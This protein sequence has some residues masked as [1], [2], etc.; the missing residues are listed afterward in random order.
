MKKHWYSG[1][2]LKMASVL[3]ALLFI[4]LIFSGCGG[5]GGGDGTAAITNPASS[6]TT[7]VGYDF[8]K[9]TVKDMVLTAD[10]ED[11][12]YDRLEKLLN[13][14]YCYAANAPKRA[15]AVPYLASIVLSKKT[16]EVQTSASYDLAGITV[17]STMSSGTTEV[18]TPVWAIYSGV[19]AL[20]GS[21]YTAP[22]VAGTTVFIACYKKDDVTRYAIFRLKMNGLSSLVLSKTTDE[23]V[24]AGTYDL[25]GITVSA[26]SSTGALVDVT[27]NPNTKWA[28]ASG[29][30]T[31]VGTTYVAPA[32][33][34]TSVFTVSYVE[35]G[36]VQ[37]TMF[38]LK[39]NGL[40]SLVLSKYTDEVLLST[41]PA[42]YDLSAIA[43][44][45]KYSNGTIKD[46]TA[47]PNLTWTLY[48][49]KGTLNGKIYTTAAYAETAVLTANYTE[50]GMTK[51]ANFVLKVNALYSIFLNKTT[52]EIWL[53]T[54]PA[55]YDLSSIVVSAKY[56]NSAIKDV[57]S[58]PNTVWT[59]Y[60]GKGTLSGKVYTTAAYAETATLK[61]T[62]TEAGVSK[63]AYFSLKVIALYSISLDPPTGA[64][65][66]SGQFDLSTVIVTAKYSNNSTKDVTAD[67]NTTWTK[68]SGKGTLAGKIYTATAAA[69]TAVFTA[70]Y[71]EAGVS[72]TATFRL[73]VITAPAPSV[74]LSDDDPVGAVNAHDCDLIKITAK[75]TSLVPI[76][77]TTVPTISI[78]TIVTNA[79]MTKVSNL[80]W[81]YDWDVPAG[82]YGE[83]NVTITATNAN[84][85]ANA[86][87]TGKTKYIIY[88]PSS[89][90][91]NPI[92]VETG[93]PV[94]ASTYPYSIATDSAGN[95]YS[96]GCSTGNIDVFEPNGTPKP[97]TLING[98]GC[99]AEYYSG[100]AVD[101]SN[102]YIYIT[103]CGNHR[104]LKYTLNMSY[105]SEWGSNGSNNGMFNFPTGIAVD[106][107]GNV[108]V[109]DGGNDRIQ[110][111]GPSGNFISKYKVNFVSPISNSPGFIS[112]DNSGNFFVTDYNGQQFKK[113]DSNGNILWT[114]GRYHS[115]N[116]PENFECCV[117]HYPMGLTLDN[118]GNAYVVDEWTSSRRVKIY[119]PNGNLIK[120]WNVGDLIDSTDYPYSIALDNNGNTYVSGGRSSKIYKFSTTPTQTQNYVYDSQWLGL[121]LPI[122]IT[123]DSSGYIYVTDQGNKIRKYDSNGNM[124]LEWGSY[125]SGDGQFYYPAGIVVDPSGNIYVVD[126]Y[127][128]RIQKFDANGNFITKWGTY[129]S[130]D[131]QF[132]YPFGISLDSTGNVYVADAYNHRIQKFDSN[133]TFLGWLGG[134]NIGGTGWHSPGSGLTA[135]ANS[136]DGQFNWASDVKIDSNGNIYVADE[137]NNRIQKFD[138]NGNFI[139]KWGSHGSENGQF[140]YPTVISLD[141]TGNFFI[142]DSYN[143]RIQ[144]FDSNGN[145]ITII[146]SGMLSYSFY[147]VTVDQSG[148]VYAAD[149]SNNRIVKFVPTN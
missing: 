23:V 26:K 105:V 12:Y 88:A 34:E 84:G 115:P 92:K 89:I 72:K 18:V 86:P 39:I 69:E 50:A 48:S 95:V 25:A 51:T 55:A 38:T 97:G 83:H 87:A 61:A 60:S 31:L 137:A 140:Y 90:V 5:S 63:Y 11:E 136:G 94:I 56:S 101:S 57:S 76:N 45:M 82:N 79:V 78:G 142:S 110:K 21:I 44:S 120:V 46:V 8:S 36:I 129:G 117:F 20:S 85:V 22:P 67:L 53:I 32:L 149:T 80:E 102:G 98:F 10:N 107:M 65:A 64:V 29:R 124:I 118:F 106:S 74:V 93:W 143:S 37:S 62:Y 2:N 33:A 43:V 112:I 113:I 19:N 73:S 147:G 139:T 49:G 54:G 28:I 42:N 17:T 130:G 134:D 99:N 40:L 138:S 41:G 111:F 59:V 3:S 133:G 24:S 148:N 30:G 103:D 116:A 7:V 68:T 1:F 71:T 119:D 121:C 109:V 81:T 14:E 16:D 125:G 70:K 66:L 13:E 104:V 114:R 144:K 123:T 100:I 77:E 108:Y 128:N 132:Y 58:D 141:S 9:V 35:G 4:A 75:F 91:Y 96:L 47:S 122:G 27:S 127:N 145:F 15:P 135:I 6:T 131:S 52:D 126:E 146:G